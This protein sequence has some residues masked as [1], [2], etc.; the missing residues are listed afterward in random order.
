MRKGM[1]NCVVCGSE[2]EVC[3]RCPTT[4]R[5]TPW[6]VICDTPVHYQVYQLIQEIKMGILT[7]EDAKEM[8]AHI[9][10]TKEDV[11]SFL[12]DARDFLLPIFDEPKD[13]SKKKSKKVPV[14]EEFTE[15]AEAIIEAPAEEPV[16]DEIAEIE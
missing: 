6:R 15:P 9:N 1:V 7:N 13:A 11:E 8:L 16:I 14:I 2:Y 5:N 3:R 12:P 10:I 4:T